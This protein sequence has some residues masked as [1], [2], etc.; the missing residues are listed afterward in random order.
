[1]VEIIFSL[2]SKNTISGFILIKITNNQQWSVGRKRGLSIK[3]NL[4]LKCP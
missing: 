3:I 4:A 1:M 2:L